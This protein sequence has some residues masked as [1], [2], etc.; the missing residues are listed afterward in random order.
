MTRTN[1]SLS[2][3]VL[4]SIVLALAGCGG[5]SDPGVAKLAT[6]AAS[7][8]STPAGDG[9]PGGASASSGGGNQ[10]G[11]VHSE[12]AIAGPG[13][14]EA[15]KKMV[16]FA[17]CMRSHGVSDFPEP[18]E[19]KLI[20]RGGGGAGP[21]RGLNPGSP[22][23]RSAMKACHSLAPAPKI[24]PQQ[25][26]AMQAQALKFSECMRSH[27]VPNFPDPK[28]EGGGVRMRIGGGPGGVNPQSPQFQAAQKACQGDFPGPGGPKG[29]PGA[30]R[31]A[32]A[33]P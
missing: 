30:V 7:S 25:T 33:G 19:G 20:I 6:T 9:A 26:A 32:P 28:F 21:N 11:E 1:L 2:V 22:Q 13:G 29:G 12:A 5:S 24:S 18:T 3:V 27:G 4:A 23:F 14:P 16:A 17:Q 15:Q 10:G 8:T 31:A